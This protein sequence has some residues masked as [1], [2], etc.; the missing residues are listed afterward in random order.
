MRNVLLAMLFKKAVPKISG[1]FLENHLQHS[2]Y[3]KLITML[4]MSSTADVFSSNFPKMYRTAILKENHPMDVPYFINNTSIWVLL[5]RQHFAGSK[6]SSKLTLETKWYHSCSC[7]DDSQSCE[8]L[9]KCIIVK[10]FE[11]KVRLWSLNTL[12]YWKCMSPL[13]D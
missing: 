5:F 1:E 6:T 11:K 12:H 7:C 3:W 2:P 8:Q 4:N 9:K 13:E 10:Y